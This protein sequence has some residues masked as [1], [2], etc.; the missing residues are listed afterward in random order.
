MCRT[1]LAL[2]NNRVPAGQNAPQPVKGTSST[3]RDAT[4]HNPGSQFSGLS[5]THF[6]NHHAHLQKHHTHM[7]SNRPSCWR[8]SIGCC[9]DAR[10][11]AQQATDMTGQTLRMLTDRVAGR[12]L[13]AW[14]QVRV[15]SGTMY[16]GGPGSKK[17]DRRP[18]A[19]HLTAVEYMESSSI[20]LDAPQQ[21]KD[22]ARG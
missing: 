12:H 9:C 21:W 22:T 1:V 8:N 18:A 3:L 15:C 5:A 2:Q 16:A 4:V 6:H 10:E 19:L 20:S 14:S 7:G 17:Q 13:G 11:M